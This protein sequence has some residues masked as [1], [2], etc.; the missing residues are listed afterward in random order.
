M[1]FRTV[2]RSGLRVS[3]I[4]LGCN[5]L[6]RSGTATET[7]E[8]SQAVVSAAIDAGITFFDTADV[9]GKEYGLS[10]ALL[11][12][13]LVGRRDEVV[14]ATKFGHTDIPSPL[15]SWGAGGSR[16][17][18]RL[19]VEGSLRRLRTDWIDLYQL[20]TPDPFTPIEETLD[21][22]DELVTEG[23][24]R[25]VGC[26]NF[27]AWHVTEAEFTAR[28]RGTQ[29]FLTAQNEY[30]MLRRRGVEQELLPALERY[31]IGLLPYFPLYNGLLTGKFTRRGGP[32]DSRIMRQRRHLLENAPWD[33]LDAYEDFCR[34]RGIPM[35]AATFGWLLSRPQVPSVIAGATTP[36]QVRANAETGVS[37]T[38]E[39]DDLAELDALFSEDAPGV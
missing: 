8:G 39:A 16:R 28:A 19:A 23:K 26:S 22:L 20:H 31:Q 21:A 11:G 1:E 36:D 24:V 10:E 5:N 15:T 2:G 32:D 9:Y 35:L 29:R 37:W 6:G 17:Y 30:S 27:A 25:Y 4:G 14:V 12:E 3:A 18:V 13:A 33:V 34:K 7:K 38:P